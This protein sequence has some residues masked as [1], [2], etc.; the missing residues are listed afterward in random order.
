MNNF[1]LIVS[2]TSW[3]GRIFSEILQLVIFSLIRQT[4]DYRYKIVL[5]LS[6]DEFPKK[7]AELPDNIVKMARKVDN[8]EILWTKENTKAYKKYFPTKRKYPNVPIVTIDDDS[9]AKPYFINTLM[10]LHSKDK[11]RVIYGYDRMPHMYGG[12]DCVRY[13]VALYP[14]SSLY[15]L[16]EAF[17]RK[18][19]KDMDDEFMRLLHVLA[20][21]HFFEIQASSILHMQ[22]GSQDVAMQR[23]MANQWTELDTMWDNVFR[24]NPE[25]KRKW[26]INKRIPN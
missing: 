15:P 16:E 17:G 7:E 19:F 6:T 9:P 24:S 4:T 18:Y 10:A 26:D 21:T 13:G 2:L 8:F 5:V 23:I 20:G 22:A 1:D 11:R 3:K 25:L 14:P 12:I